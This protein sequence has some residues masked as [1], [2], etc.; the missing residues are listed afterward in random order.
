MLKEK[1]GHTQIIC[2]KCQLNFVFR[3]LQ[4]LRED[5][6][7]ISAYRSL[8]YILILIFFFLIF[9]LKYIYIYIE[10]GEK[11]ERERERELHENVKWESKSKKLITKSLDRSQ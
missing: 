11:M 6:S 5:S 1:C 8:F 3:E 10:R 7:I 9:K 4:I 2:C